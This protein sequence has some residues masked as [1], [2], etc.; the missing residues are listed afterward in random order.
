MTRRYFEATQLFSPQTA[1]NKV[2]PISEQSAWPDAPGQH[3]LSPKPAC[4][5][6][7]YPIEAEQTRRALL[8]LDASVTPC[9]SPQRSD[10]P[11]VW[12][13]GQ[14]W[15]PE[16]RPPAAQHSGEESKHFLCPG[17]PARAAPAR[18][19]LG[20]ATRHSDQMKIV[21]VPPSYGV[22]V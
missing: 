22:R 1:P 10:D 17:S 2:G 11:S 16:L 9:P 21:T 5:R 4:H 18:S 12:A 14:P 8:P 19:D 3:H 20:Q 6:P 15:E 7:S 13:A